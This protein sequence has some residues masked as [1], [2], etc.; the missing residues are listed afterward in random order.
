MLCRPAVYV[1]STTPTS[2]DA[3]LFG[4][5]ARIRERKLA[6]GD[7]QATDFVD[8][9]ELIRVDVVGGIEVLELAGSVRAAR[10]R[11]ETSDVRDAAGPG[12][13]PG[14]VFSWFPTETREDS[15]PR[16]RNALHDGSL[17][18]SALARQLDSMLA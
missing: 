13:Q 2:R 16:D 9:A 3:V 17:S 1:P 12:E 11:I 14:K 15:E 7:G 6:R 18:H 5:D 10:F 4:L 8:P